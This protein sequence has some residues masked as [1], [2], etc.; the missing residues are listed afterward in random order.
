MNLWRSLTQRLFG[1]SL[2]WR[3]VHAR[4]SGVH[5]GKACSIGPEVEIALSTITARR[6][7][8]RVGDR[9][10]LSRGTIL[11]PYAGSIA[12]G[13]DV[14]I[15]PS[16]VIY[17]HGGVEIGDACLIAMH[18]RI[19]SSSHSIAAFGTDIRWQADEL[20]PTKIGRDVWLGAGV[21]VLGGVSIADGCVVGAGAVVT[22]DLPAG[23]IAVGVPAVIRGFRTGA[24]PPNVP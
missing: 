16:T 3:R 23:A 6:G 10:Q 12:I 11:H 22:H 21:T 14:H 24:P 1:V 2:S 5:L 8:I 19:L 4:F 20:K 13:Q 9:T 7:E 18:C 17:G 15:G